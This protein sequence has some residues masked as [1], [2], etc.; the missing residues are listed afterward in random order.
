MKFRAMSPARE[1]VVG[2]SDKII[3]KDCGRMHLEANEQIS[4]I[5]ISG[6]EYDVTAKNWGFY[7]I[8]S[9]NGRLRDQG[10]KT[11][12]VRNTDGKYYIMIVEREKVNQFQEYLKDDNQ[13]VVEWLD[14]RA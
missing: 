9:M 4:F 2:S 7:A 3:I 6:K 5:T 12:L 14:E 10:F 13:E 11:A 8:P 1:F